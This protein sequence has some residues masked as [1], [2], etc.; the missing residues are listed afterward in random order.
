MEVCLITHEGTYLRK[1]VMENMAW[2]CEELGI[3]KDIFTND[4]IAAEEIVFPSL[5]KY[6]TGRISKRYCGW[7]P[8]I[9]EEDVQSV[10]D[11]GTCKSLAGHW[12]NILKIPRDMENPMRKMLTERTPQ[13]L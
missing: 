11:T 2:I 1:N 6:L 10:I 13:F 4:V 5:E 7:I 8:G 9:K 12:N 3:N